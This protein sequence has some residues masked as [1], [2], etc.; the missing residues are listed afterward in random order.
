MDEMLARAFDSQVDELMMQ[1]MMTEML[2]PHFETEQITATL[3]NIDLMA[4][5]GEMEAETPEDM[6]E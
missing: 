6:Q 4:L 2:A 1:D 5:L 3:D